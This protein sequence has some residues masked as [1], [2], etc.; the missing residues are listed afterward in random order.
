VRVAPGVRG[1]LVALV[2]RVF[3]AL[4]LVLVVDAPAVCWESVPVWEGWD[5]GLTV[6]AICGRYVR[7]EGMEE[8]GLGWTH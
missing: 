4:C 2:E 8:I 6:V 5:W 3:H 1:D 7:K